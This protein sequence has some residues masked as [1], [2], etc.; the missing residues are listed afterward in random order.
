MLHTASLLLLTLLS[1]GCSTLAS[2]A[3][4]PE[5]IM[6]APGFGGSAR[7]E[8]YGQ[9]PVGA[10]ALTDAL[11]STIEIS[12]LF[13][14]ADGGAAADWILTVE[15]LEVEKPEWALDMTSEVTLRWTLE[16]GSGQEVWSERIETLFKASPEDEPDVEAR[17]DFALASAV[18][19]NLARAVEQMQALER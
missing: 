16:S 15:V 1:F 3:M 8:V 13:D 6:A 5:S 12:G 18:R 7:L 4:T 9:G 17:G 11:R 10:E 14:R 2:E 19:A